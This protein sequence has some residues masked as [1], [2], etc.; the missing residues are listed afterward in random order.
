M[1]IENLKEIFI[2]AQDSQNQHQLVKAFKKLYNEVSALSLYFILN[3]EGTY[4]VGPIMP[5]I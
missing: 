2:S 4:I 1:G 3:Y 5:M